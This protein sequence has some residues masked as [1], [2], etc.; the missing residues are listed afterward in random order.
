MKNVVL[1][2]AACC[3]E[4]SSMGGG[5][6]EGPAFV[7]SITFWLFGLQSGNK[8]LLK[9]TSTRKILKIDWS[10]QENAEFRFPTCLLGSYGY[11]LGEKLLNEDLLRLKNIYDRG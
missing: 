11:P 2:H 9:S 5:R 3:Y 10:I 4:N 6:Q 1:E 8:I 7:D